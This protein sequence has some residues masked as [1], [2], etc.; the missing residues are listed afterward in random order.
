MQTLQVT[1]KISKPVITPADKLSLCVMV[2]TQL[3]GA[4][5]VQKLSQQGQ[6][7]SDTAIKALQCSDFLTRQKE[8]VTQGA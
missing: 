5:H 1:A 3:L 2:V 4:E 8:M 7:Q 6:G